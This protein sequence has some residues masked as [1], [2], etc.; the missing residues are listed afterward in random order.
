VRG[1]ARMSERHM[2]SVA[3]SLP[4]IQKAEGLYAR[5]PTRAHAGAGFPCWWA[6]LGWF[7][8]SIVPSFSFSFYCQAWKFIGNSRKMVKLCDQFC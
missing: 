7:Q 4:V 6:G 5:W 2:N 8:P 3:A 1:F